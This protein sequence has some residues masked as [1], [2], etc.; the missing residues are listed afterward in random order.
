VKYTF[1]NAT[2]GTVAYRSFTDFGMD[3]ALLRAGSLPEIWTGSPSTSTHRYQAEAATA[4]TVGGKICVDGTSVGEVCSIKILKSN[5]CQKFEDG[6]TTCH[7]VKAQRLGITTGRPGDSGAPVY[8]VLSN[9]HLHVH[10]TYLGSENADQ[11]AYYH[12]IR[13]VLS[14]FGATMSGG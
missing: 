14:T 8:T 10:G 1:G 9:G 3:I 13:Y 12:P 11:D 2:M 6:I 7:V 5:Y 4:D